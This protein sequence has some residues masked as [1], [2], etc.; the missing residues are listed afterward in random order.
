[1]T[2]EKVEQLMRNAGMPAI[3]LDSS[4]EQ[5]GRSKLGGLPQVPVDF[6]WPTWKG[7]PL[8]FIAQIDLASLPHLDQM[9]DLPDSGFLYFF[10]DQEQ[11]TWGFDPKDIG[12]WSVVY[13]EQ[14]NDLNEATPP[15]GLSSEAIY[16]EKFVAPYKMISYPSL[17]RLGID[18]RILPESDFDIEYKLYS[19]TFNDSPMHQLGGFPNAVQGDDMELEAQLASNG[20][21]CG[22]STGYQ[23]PRAK[24]LATGSTDWQLL[25]QIDT[26]D[27]TGMMWGDCGRLYFW[28]KRQ[29]LA[30]NDFSKV[31]MI[32]Q[33]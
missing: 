13:L 23:D 17:E 4:D 19:Q 21:Y 15:L 1:M 20:L 22:N 10:Y 5:K 33:C 16:K 18:F 6:K 11:S 9:K 26:D 24:E 12:S 7:R 2:D 31:W 25:L 29:E 28:I 32:L 8:A 27:D 30:E 3:H 14:T